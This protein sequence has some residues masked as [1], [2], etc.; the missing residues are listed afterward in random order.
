MKNILSLSIA[1]FLM[2]SGVAN[3]GGSFSATQ[4]T[5]LGFQTGG[6]YIY[7]NWANK[8][9]CSHTDAV[10]LPKSDSNFDN[11]YSLI[12][13]AYISGKK[14]SGYS[15]GCHSHDGKTYNTIRGHKYLVSH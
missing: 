15:D 5:K 9:G 13:A 4:I 10:V 8:N 14:I 11:A 2:M 1:I 6:L 3:A 12:M 7:G